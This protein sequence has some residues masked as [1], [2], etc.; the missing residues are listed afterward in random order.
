MSALFMTVD[1]VDEVPVTYQITK[2]TLDEHNNLRL[3]TMD[4]GTV[5]VNRYCWSAYRMS[6]GSARRI[7][8]GTV[9]P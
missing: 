1:R 5:T 9:E 3:G 2:A 4:G 7:T 8:D 6:E